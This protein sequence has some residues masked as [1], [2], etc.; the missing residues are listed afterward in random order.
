[1]ARRVLDV[2][3]SST[4]MDLAAHR[5]ALRDRLTRTGFFHCVWQEDFGPQNAGAV[6][7]CRQQAQKSELFVGLIGLRRGWEPDGDNAKRSITEMEHEWA[8]EAGRRRFLWVAPDDFPVP[9]NLRESDHQH[10]RQMAFR[11]RL[12][13]DGERIV[14]QKGF[15]SPE[16]LA[17]EIVEHLLAQLITSDLIIQLR[18]ELTRQS[19]QLSDQTKELSRSQSTAASAGARRT[20]AAI[21]PEEQFLL[22]IAEGQN[23]V[24]RRDLDAALSAFSKAQEIARD[25]KSRGQT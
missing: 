4:G 5:V 2:F 23:A 6:E 19:E 24:A 7:F 16:L 11:A 12:M 21:E 25:H 10:Q 15:G 13:A 18:P 3:L 9:G 17:A 20:N 22:L 1:M 8:K 14:S